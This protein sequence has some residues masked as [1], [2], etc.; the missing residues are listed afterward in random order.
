M[1]VLYTLIVNGILNEKQKFSIVPNKYKEEFTGDKDVQ[2]YIHNI[3]ILNK[4][5]NDQIK[6]VQ[7]Q[8]NS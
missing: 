3:K 4:I 1:T 8:I 6:S 7:R 2:T 5:K